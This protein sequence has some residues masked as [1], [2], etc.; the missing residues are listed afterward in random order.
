MSYYKDQVI[1]LASMHEKE[2]AIAPPFAEK[3]SCRLTVAA[4]NTDQFGTFTGEIERK[5]SPYATCL[6]KARTA[7]EEHGYSLAIASEG[8]F[9]P[10]PAIPFMPGAHELMLLVDRERDWVIAEQLFSTKTNYAQMI[11]DKDSNLDAFLERVQFPSH[12]VIVQG[13]A[14][15]SLLSKGIRDSDA[16]HHCLDLGFKKEK[17]LILS[18]DMR[19]MMNPS[20]MEVIGELA[21]KLAQRIAT[22]CPECRVPGFGFKQ[23]AGSLP[24]AQ[25]AASTS[26][27]QQ[28]IWACIDCDYQE[29]R[30]RRD[31]LEMADPAYCEYCNP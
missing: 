23:T 6:L 11:I 27:Y 29:F 2:R 3:L 10:H 13:R 20:R 17:Q 4:F 26:F 28:E 16:L 25:C 8:S 14:D 15:S 19:A 18:T 5:S 21:D 12:A 1:L 30:K 24:C 9:G 7:A 22:L 31:G